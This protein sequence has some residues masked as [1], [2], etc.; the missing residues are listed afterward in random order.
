MP[1]SA[2]A[3]LCQVRARCLQ[4]HTQCSF[5]TPMQAL[6]LGLSPVFPTPPF[7]HAVLLVPLL[8]ASCAVPM[9]GVR[10]GVGCAGGV[11]QCLGCGRKGSSLCFGAMP[12]HAHFTQR[13]FYGHGVTL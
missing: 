8:S 1:S 3:R 6:S 10:A 13:V 11:R 12:P 4:S 2:G 5:L 7:L 9:E